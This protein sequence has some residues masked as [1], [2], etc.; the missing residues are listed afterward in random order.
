MASASAAIILRH[1]RHMVGAPAV[2][3]RPDRELLR[4]FTRDGDGQ[5]FAALL[6]RHGPMVWAACRRVLPNTADAEDVLQKTFLL[7]AQKAARLRDPDSVGRRP[8]P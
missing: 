6:R 5:A 1:I 2:D 4:R 7:L 3:D 8:R